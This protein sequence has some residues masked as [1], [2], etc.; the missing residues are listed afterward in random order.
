[1]YSQLARDRVERVVV[2]GRRGI[3]GRRRRV[4]SGTRRRPESHAERARAL[5]QIGHLYVRELDDHELATTIGGMLHT[6]PFLIANLHVAL[7]AAYVVVVVE[8]LAVAEFGGQAAA[9]VVARDDTEQLSFGSDRRD[10][11]RPEYPARRA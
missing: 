5:N 10:V 1:M 4:G 2:G 7:R 8:L 9:C 3:A 11:V 6:F